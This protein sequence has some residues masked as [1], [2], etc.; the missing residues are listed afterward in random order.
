[1]FQNHINFVT[2][3]DNKKSAGKR[4]CSVLS[5]GLT[6]E[7]RSQRTKG[8]AGLKNK[9]K[10]SLCKRVA[11]LLD[12]IRIRLCTS[13]TESY[14]SSALV[15]PAKRD[16]NTCLHMMHLRKLLGPTFV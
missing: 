10:P 12:L 3:S 9:N 8:E 16:V 2:V 6:T 7:E 5:K 1:M 4:Q 15:S 13:L 14:M 11:P